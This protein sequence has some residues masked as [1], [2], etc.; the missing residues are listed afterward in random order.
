[1]HVVSLKNNLLIWLSSMMA[2]ASIDYT[3]KYTNKVSIKVM[4]KVIRFVYQKK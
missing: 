1:M 2:F 4:H 3:N